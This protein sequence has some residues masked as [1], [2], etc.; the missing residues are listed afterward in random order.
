MRV[1]A[2]T[3]DILNTCLNLH[4]SKDYIYLKK[5]MEGKNMNVFD[6]ETQ[7]LA[8]ENQVQVQSYNWIQ[9]ELTDPNEMTLVKN[10][11]S[12]KLSVGV[13][14]HKNVVG[15]W[16]SHE[17]SDGTKQIWFYYFDQ[18]GRLTFYTKENASKANTFIQGEGDD[19][20]SI[21]EMKLLRALNTDRPEAHSNRR[22]KLEK[23]PSYTK[24]YNY[25]NSSIETLEKMLQET[26]PFNMDTIKK[27]MIEFAL[28]S[29]KKK[30][31]QSS[32]S[33]TPTTTTETPVTTP[34]TT[35]VETTT[36]VVDTPVEQTLTKKKRVFLPDEDEMT[37]DKSV[38][39]STKEDESPQ[40]KRIIDPNNNNNEL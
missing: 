14:N 29:K 18:F 22:I 1:N 30:L 20:I 27:S 4:I 34:V 32:T 35:P 19:V 16:I 36:M 25:Q 8:K 39:S 10:D 37:D 7:K 28:E 11:G 13:T 3:S 38:V 9:Q 2:F 33:T 26:D 5:K 23:E 21:H 12:T 24:M 17:T 15:G 6:L 31:V 40:K